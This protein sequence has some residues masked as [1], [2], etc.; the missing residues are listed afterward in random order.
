MQEVLQNQ[1]IFNF[2]RKEWYF[3]SQFSQGNPDEARA[4]RVL[5]KDYVSGKLLYGHP[6]PQMDGLEFNQDLYHNQAY[7]KRKQKEAEKEALLQQKNALKESQKSATS[8][9]STVAI[10]NSVDYEFFKENLI[11]ICYR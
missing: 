7:L 6:P 2:Y 9:P 11:K 4:A 1:G 10:H 8:K 3:N 5:L